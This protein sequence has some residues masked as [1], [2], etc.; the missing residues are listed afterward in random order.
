MFM[1]SEG[2]RFF[3]FRRD[4]PRLVLGAGRRESAGRDFQRGEVMRPEFQGLA[5]I[6]QRFGIVLARQGQCSGPHQHG[7][8]L[9]RALER[10][11]QILLSRSALA[12]G[13]EEKGGLG[14]VNAELVRVLE[15]RS[16]RADGRRHVGN[17]HAAHEEHAP[18][19][20]PGEAEIRSLREVVEQREK[21]AELP[22]QEHSVEP[23]LAVQLAPE[24]GR[25]D[26]G[27]IF[28]RLR[29]KGQVLH[30][31]ARVRVDEDPFQP[32]RGGVPGEFRGGFQARIQRLGFAAAAREHGKGEKNGKMAGEAHGRP[33]RKGTL[34]K[35]SKLLRCSAEQTLRT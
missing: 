20:H 6:L 18:I 23:L 34:A 15:L 16:D 3:Q 22:G 1:S 11:F 24:G 28:G 30:R 33:Q 26:R 32:A 7:R 12:D 10:G 35:K 8:L 5:G 25:L 19:V 9:G 13:I 14:Q 29:G 2:A 31:G 21:F 27:R 17:R 4:F